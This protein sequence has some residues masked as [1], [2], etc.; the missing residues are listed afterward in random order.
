MCAFVVQDMENQMREAL[1]NIYFSKTKTVV[2]GMYMPASRE[3]QKEELQ[4][5]LR[6]S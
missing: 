3:K 5:Q 4:R 6:Q 1:Q 2:N